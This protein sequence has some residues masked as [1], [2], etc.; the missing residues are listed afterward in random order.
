M[1]FFFM[2]MPAPVPFRYRL[3]HF[4]DYV[5][6]KYTNYF[7]SVAPVFFDER[8]VIS[9]DNYF[10][11]SLWQGGIFSLKLILPSRARIFLK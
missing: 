10:L 3:I 1:A 2:H 5:K 9:C 4:L 11:N 7:T 6:L 8:M